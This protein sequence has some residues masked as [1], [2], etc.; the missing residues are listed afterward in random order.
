MSFGL[1]VWRDRV[2]TA[3]VKAT[4]VTTEDSRPSDNKDQMQTKAIN[5]STSQFVVPKEQDL[6][7]P[8]KAEEALNTSLC[9]AHF[10]R[11]SK[12]TNPPPEPHLDLAERGEPRV[13]CTAQEPRHGRAI[14]P[15]KRKPHLPLL[16]RRGAPVST[17]NAAPTTS[18]PSR[19]VCHYFRALFYT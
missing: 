8:I 18:P 3:V 16:P 9:L 2:P 17:D 1:T 13:R 10:M 7:A 14:A 11:H 15:K 4:P 19:H 6:S 12:R 5:T